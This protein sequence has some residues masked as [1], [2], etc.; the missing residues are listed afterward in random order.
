[1]TKK[2]FCEVETRRRSNGDERP[3]RRHVDAVKI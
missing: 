2:K 3:Q 1:M